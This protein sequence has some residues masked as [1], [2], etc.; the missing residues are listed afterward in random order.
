MFHFY[1]DQF[2]S[3]SLAMRS[4]CFRVA[5]ISFYIR[6]FKFY[7]CSLQNNCP[8]VYNANLRDQKVAQK[9]GLKE[10]VL[11]YHL[12]TR[13]YLLRQLK[14]GFPSSQWLLEEYICEI[15]GSDK[16]ILIPV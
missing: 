12:K 1:F 8:T 4:F 16:M 11:N 5:K 2:E 10:R 15:L 14:H 3:V 13:N 6:D 7:L 9:P